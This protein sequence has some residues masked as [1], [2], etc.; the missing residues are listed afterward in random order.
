MADKTNATENL[1]AIKNQM[2]DEAESSYTPKQLKENLRLLSQSNTDGDKDELSAVEARNYLRKFYEEPPLSKAARSGIAAQKHA[3]V[4]DCTS[5]ALDDKNSEASQKALQQIPRLLAQ[6]L[7]FIKSVALMMKEHG[8]DQ[9]KEKQMENELIKKYAGVLHDP[10]ADSMIYTHTKAV[11]PEIAEE[12]A[13][14][15]IKAI[16]QT[17][18]QDKKL[19]D[20][21]LH[22]P[23]LS[24]LSHLTPNAICIAI[25]Q[26]EPGH[27]M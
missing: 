24:A 14:A 20:S 21:A 5:V 7:S 25:D 3:V 11:N 12:Q 2:R 18:G 4:D 9:D 17:L 27:K 16:R 26:P 6:D 19:L 8:H 23:N 10:N 22:I 1:I 13:K 15:R